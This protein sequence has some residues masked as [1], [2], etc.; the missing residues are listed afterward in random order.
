MWKPVPYLW[1][2]A[3]LGTL[4]EQNI[5]KWKIRSSSEFMHISVCA[6]PALT[7]LGITA[8]GERKLFNPCS[9]IYLCSTSAPSL[10]VKTKVLWEG[11]ETSSSL[12]N[13]RKQIKANVK[14]YTDH[15][16][17]TERLIQIRLEHSEELLV[18]VVTLQKLSQCLLWEARMKTEHASTPRVDIS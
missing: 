15:N 17:N 6:L 16:E 10:W 8:S 18:S 11:W 7:S 14:N 4:Q 1:A 2:T 5:T 3:R 13:R 9:H 12:S